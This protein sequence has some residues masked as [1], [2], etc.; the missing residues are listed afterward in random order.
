M[1][2]PA[3]GEMPKAE[4]V[5]LESKLFDTKSTPPVRPLSGEELAESFDVESIHFFL[6]F[7]K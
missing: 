6:F 4:G 7:G 2:P 3:K 5:H 1:S